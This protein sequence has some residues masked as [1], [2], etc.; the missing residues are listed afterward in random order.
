M[1]IPSKQFNNAQLIPHFVELLNQGHT[2][3]FK[4][5]GFSM[6]PF[7]EDGRD[8]A[9]LS[10]HTTV[11]RGDEVLAEISPG[12][13]VLH[14][15]VNIDG[16]KVTLRGDGNLNTEQCSLADIRGIATAFYRKGRS[17]PDYTSGRKWRI[18]SAI[19]TR[20]LPIRRYLLFIYR[21][22]KK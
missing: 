1:P 8:C 14:R 20:L 4:L 12:R 21:K 5:R 9:I 17:T 3:T 6:R 18:Y 22:V 7:L 13:Y 2:V 19:W 10:K 16:D 11:H 15:I